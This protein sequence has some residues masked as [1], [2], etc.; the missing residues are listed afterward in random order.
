MNNKFMDT[1]IALILL[2]LLTALGNAV[3]LAMYSHQSSSFIVIFLEGLLAMSVLA[4]IAFAGYLVGMLPKFNKLP[5]ILWASLIAAFV[6]SPYFPYSTELLAITNK[7]SLL[8]ICTP[9]LAFAGLSLGKDIAQFKDIS[10][11]IIPVSLAVFT[12]TFIFAAL[13][14]QITLKWEGIIP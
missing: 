7:V 8:V 13:I 5:V 3:S 4:C 1:V 12:G 2:S 10:W 14:A 9:V 6:S 11:K